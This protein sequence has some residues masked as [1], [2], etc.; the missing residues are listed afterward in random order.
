M[1]KKHGK[2]LSHWLDG[3]KRGKINQT[4]NTGQPWLKMQETFLIKNC[5]NYGNYSPQIW[6]RSQISK[7][8]RICKNMGTFFY[9]DSNWIQIFFL[10]KGISIFPEC[11][12]GGGRGGILE[13]TRKLFPGPLK[14]Q[15]FRNL[16][17]REFL[18]YRGGGGKHS[19]IGKV[20]FFLDH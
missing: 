7:R 17:R 5:K 19:G 16:P 20:F 1:W 14:Q 10:S 13:F 8:F 4:V 18:Y 6:E 15:K 11:V 2:M 9:P 12:Y 3:N